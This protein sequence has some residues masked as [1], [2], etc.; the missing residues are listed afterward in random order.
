[1]LTEQEKAE[2]KKGCV[3]LELVMNNSNLWGR[4]VDGKT[5]F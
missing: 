1:M 5:V 3:G 2:A 4:V